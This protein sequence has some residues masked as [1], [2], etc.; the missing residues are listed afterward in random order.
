[1]SE[2]TCEPISRS[3]AL[4]R[5]MQW[6][7]A[8]QGQAVRDALENDF[9]GSLDPG[10]YEQLKDL[11][12]DSFDGIMVNATEWL[13]AD[14]FFFAKGQGRRVSELL[15]ERGGPL[16]FAEQRQWLELLVSKPL[17]LYEVVGL[18]PGGNMCLKDILL[19]QLPPVL[20]Q[21]KA[22]SQKAVRF[23][24]LAARVLPLDGHHELSG[25]LYSFPRHRSED[26][27]AE[28]RRE[29]EGVKPDSIFAKEI[30]SV[31]I[32]YHWLKLFVTPFE[33]SQ[34]F[35]HMHR[36]PL[37]L[38]TDHYR[39]QDWKALG[40]ALS[41]EADVESN[42]EKGWSRFFEGE[43]GLPLRKGVTIEPGK[44]S[45][46]LKVSYCTIRYANVGRFWFERIARH[47]A[48]FVSRKVYEP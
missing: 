12:R 24:L 6:L 45:D 3:N 10:D 41:A 20:V 7:M 43:N 16:L 39:V 46:R 23:D 44:C 36:E 28:L 22:G 42:S 5:A 40:Q 26:L 9:F 14:G 21:E 47:T 8:M 17:R 27:I 30:T 38:V 11:C 34:F 2:E 48:I 1:M 33:I 4:K 13:L 31:I 35:D 29:L 25:A 19:P 18:E 15:L 32:P 37:L